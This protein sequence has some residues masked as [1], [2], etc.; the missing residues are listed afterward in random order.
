[1]NVPE[2]AAL[3]RDHWKETCPKAYRQLEKDKLLQAE[4]EAAAKLTLREMEALMKVKMSEQ[5]AWQASRHLF[6]FL[7]KK[8]MEQMYL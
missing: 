7:T 6:I 3:A 8:Q 5:E 1:M 4:S 2:M